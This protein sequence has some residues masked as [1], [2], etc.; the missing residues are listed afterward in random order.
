MIEFN[1]KQ[2][3]DIP[4]NSI[5]KYGVRDNYIDVTDVALSKCIVDNRIIIPDGDHARANIFGDPLPYKLKSIFVED[6]GI[7]NNNTNNLK[8]K[9]VYFAYL[10]PNEWEP[11]VIEQLDSLKKCGL[12]NDATDIYISLLAN[13]TE[14]QKIKILLKKYSKI[15]IINRYIDNVYEYPGIKALYD[16]ATHDENTILLYFHSKGMT[17]KQHRIRKL[18]FKYTIANYKDYIN[19]MQINKN[20]DVAGIFPHID[21]FIYYNFFW[22][23]SSYIKK[24]CVKPEISNDRYIWEIWI[25]NSY[26]KKQNNV[27]YSIKYGYNKN[28]SNNEAINIYNIFKL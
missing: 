11:I 20:I 5:I 24:Y 21:G 2:I 26:N 8:I 3:V 25:G 12:Y 13:D 6:K 9:I 27:T 28:K 17:S 16:I 4:I 7:Q 14:L 22:I 19:E 10:V 15:K 23:R 18:L 1:D